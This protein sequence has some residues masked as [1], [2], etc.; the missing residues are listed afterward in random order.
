MKERRPTGVV[1]IFCLLLFQGL[2]NLVTG[3]IGLSA[4]R[5]YYLD[6]AITL[7][8][9]I[10]YI[11]C[12]VGLIL[13]KEKIRKLTIISLILFF[14]ILLWNANKMMIRLATANQFIGVSIIAIIYGTAIYY[15]TRPG[16]KA[17][18]K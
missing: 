3:S 9:G 12:G 10:L 4:L 1:V 17:R 15:L 16:I 14:I 8:I 13:F 6:F 2:V 18:F 5:G 11:L 7:V